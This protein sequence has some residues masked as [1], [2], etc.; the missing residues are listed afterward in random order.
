MDKGVD[1]NYK[2]STLTHNNIVKIVTIIQRTLNNGKANTIELKSVSRYITYYISTEVNKCI[3]YIDSIIEYKNYKSKRKRSS[4]V[5]YYND[6]LLTIKDR[7]HTIVRELTN[8]IPEAYESIML[9][10]GYI[11]KAI[12][13]ELVK[14]DNEIA[15]NIKLLSNYLADVKKSGIINDDNV[16]E[17]SSILSEIELYIDQRDNICK[18]NNNNNK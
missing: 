3:R 18:I 13:G 9:P 14:I 7:L 4:S 8:S 12:F 2:R 15:Y 11:D 6:T 16:K 5:E 17:I 10:N 1:A